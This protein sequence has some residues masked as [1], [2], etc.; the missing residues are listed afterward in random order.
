MGQKLDEVC[1]AQKRILGEVKRL[2]CEKT[3]FHSE[4]H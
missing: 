2:H 1:G 3:G 4:S